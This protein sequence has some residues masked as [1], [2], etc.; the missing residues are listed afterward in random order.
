MDIFEL[1]ESVKIANKW[2]KLQT[3]TGSEVKAKSNSFYPLEPS[4]YIDALRS[5]TS[6]LVYAEIWPTSVC[7]QNC[8]FC[9]SSIHGL[10][11]AE[12]L[13][14]EVLKKVIDDLAEIENSVIRFSGGGEPFLYK[15]MDEIIRRIRT[16]NMLSFFI[17]NGSAINDATATAL[18]DCSSM[19]RFSFNG[20]DRNTYLQLHRTDDFEKVLRTMEHLANQ[21]KIKKRQEL[22]LGATFVISDSNFRSIAKAARAVKNCGLD[23]IFIRGQNPVKYLFGEA[24]REILAEQLQICHSLKDENFFVNGKLESLD[25][26]KPIKKLRKACFAAR[27]RFYIDFRG[28]VFSCF[29]G[30]CDGQINFGNVKEASI[31][32]IREGSAHLALQERLANGD[33]YSF[34]QKHCGYADFNLC[35]EEI[36]AEIIA[37]P[38]VKFKKI[39]SPWGEQFM[40][41]ESEAWF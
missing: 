28:N 27:F 10:K 33:Y 19:V 29:N 38:E 8:L 41:K 25:G 37:N 30:I 20:G 9:S 18:I 7:N 31:K 40:N 26:T 35:M 14:F 36:E 3:S 21:R 39:P 5:K 4:V 13:P 22:S 1:S 15:R 12:S 32:D 34:C 2:D 23:F 6:R 16:R 17:T 24:D 11:C